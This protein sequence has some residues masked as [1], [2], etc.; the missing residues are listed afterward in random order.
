[1]NKLMMALSKPAA[2]AWTPADITTYLWI[3]PSDLSTLYQ[4]SAGST[5]VTASGDPVGKVSDKSGSSRHIT[6]STSD[7]RPAYNVSGSI[8]SFYM[9]GSNDSI[10]TPLLSSLSTD[11]DFFMAV[12]RTSTATNI[13]FYGTVAHKFAGVVQ[14][15]NTSRPDADAGTPTYYVDGTA[16]SPTQRGAL[17]TAM[18]SGSWHVLEIRNIDGAACFTAQTLGWCDYGGFMAPAYIGGI[19]IA[20]ALSSDNRNKLRTWLGAKVGLTL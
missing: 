12:Y 13:F 20:N 3:D 6:Q 2:P 10:R 18:S 4:D 5:A 9:D 8:K 11:M 16:V 19:V 15:G 1:M 14:S 7:K 17:H